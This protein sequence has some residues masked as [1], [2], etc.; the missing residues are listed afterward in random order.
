MK[1]DADEYQSQ[2]KLCHDTQLDSDASEV[3]AHTLSC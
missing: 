1:L 3:I 2:E